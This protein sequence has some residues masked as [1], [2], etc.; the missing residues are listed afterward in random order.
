MLLFGQ[1]LSLQAD[2]VGQALCDI[3]DPAVPGLAELLEHGD[4]SFR[5]RVARVLWNFDSASSRKVMR[6]DLQ[7]ET[8]PVIKGLSEGKS[9]KVANSA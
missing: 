3:G 8:D 6:E 5:W 7:H 4:K 2:P 9:Q 1:A